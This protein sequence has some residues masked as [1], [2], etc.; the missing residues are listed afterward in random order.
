MANRTEEILGKLQADS[1]AV[2]ALLELTGHKDEVVQLF[3]IHRARS[4]DD[5]TDEQFDKMQTLIPEVV[6]KINIAGKDFLQ[7]RLKKLI[8][9]YGC[10][11]ITVLD[12]VTES[13]PTKFKNPG[14]P[15]IFDLT[16]DMYVEYIVV[17][18]YLSL[19]ENPG[20]MNN[21]YA[22]WMD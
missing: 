2:R 13:Q 1:G 15:E 21:L 6:E 16:F 14:N 17:L 7:D 4:L 5:I 20:K 18:L 11:M 3:G 19:V 22:E 8:K 10:E 9:E 12:K